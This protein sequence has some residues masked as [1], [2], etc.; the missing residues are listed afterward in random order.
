MNGKRISKKQKRVKALNSK[1]AARV[2]RHL[3]MGDQHDLDREAAARIR[4]FPTVPRL[5]QSPFPHERKVGFAGHWI[6]GKFYV[7]SN[8]E[9]EAMNVAYKTD[10]WY[11]RIDKRGNRKPRKEVCGLLET[12]AAISSGLARVLAALAKAEK[13]KFV[14]DAT[15]R[16]SEAGM[17]ELERRT[18]YRAA[19]MALHPDSEGTLSTHFGLWPI[20]RQ[21]RCLIGRSSGGKRGRRGLRNLG[22]AFITVLRHHEAICLPEELVQLP[23][24]NRQKRD[25]DDWAVGVAMDRVVREEISSLP[26]GTELLR[27]ADEYQKSAAHDWLERYQSGSAGLAKTKAERDKAVKAGERRKEAAKRLMRLKT[28]QLEKANSEHLKQFQEEQENSRKLSTDLEEV[29]AAAKIFVDEVKTLN[30]IIKP[31]PEE[32]LEMAAKRIVKERQD[33]IE[34]E[35]HLTQL[36]IDLIRALEKAGSDV[37]K[38]LGKSFLKALHALADAVGIELGDTKVRADE[39]S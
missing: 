30:T 24:K 38:Y 14:R 28:R 26:N 33:S 6:S 39:I 16:A 1:T 11:F 20:D 37:M 36:I 25:P 34:R 19:Y 2:S 15:L 8:T 27:E 32:S 4:A 21:N 23:L 10:A 35:S 22:D 9:F 31:T 29:R 5:K 12:N 13:F 18:G 3:V 17:E 7:Q